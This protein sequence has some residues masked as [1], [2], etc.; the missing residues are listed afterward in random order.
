ME[1]FKISIFS[2]LATIVTMAAGV[3]IL[4]E[5]LA[6]FHLIGAALMIVGVVGVCLPASSR[7]RKMSRQPAKKSEA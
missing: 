2:Q 5:K 7:T 3:L 4:H 1:A 6:Y